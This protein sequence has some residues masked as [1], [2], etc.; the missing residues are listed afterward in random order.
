MPTA[1][2]PKVLAWATSILHEL[3]GCNAEFRPGQYEA[4]ESAC[5]R[6]RTL[7]VQRT[8]WGK[9]LVYFI[10]TKMLRERG[11]GTTIVVSP[12]I[13]LMDNQLAAART[14][15]LA[16]EV[17]NSTVEKEDRF[18]IFDDLQSSATGI[19][20]TTPETLLTD[21][22]QHVLGH[23]RCGLFVIDEAHCIS[24][25]GHDFRLEYTRLRQVIAHLDDT[26][27]L[28]T[29]ATATDAVVDDICR[30][31]GG[32]VFVSRG[33][34]VRDSLAIQVVQAPSTRDKYAWLATNLPLIEGSGIVYCTTTHDCDQL[35]RF[36]RSEGIESVAYHSQRDASE[37]A[38]TL[39]LFNANRIK[40]LV[41]TSALGMGYDKDDIAFVVHFQLPSGIVAYYQQ[42]GRAGRAL[43]HAYAILLAG[44]KT[45][46]KIQ[47]HFIESAFPTE[48]ETQQI[49]HLIATEP[50]GIRF[51]DLIAAANIRQARVTKALEFLQNDGF[52]ERAAGRYVLTDK[53]FAY[54]RAHYEEITRRR[55]AELD[56]M[57]EL[58]R[59]ADCLSRQVVAALGDTLA[60][61]CGRCANCRGTNVFPMQAPSEDA[62]RR[63]SEFCDRD[64][65]SIRPKK[66]WPSRDLAANASDRSTVMSHVNEEGLSLAHLGR[67]PVGE[68]IEAALASDA[69]LPQE[70]LE[71]SAKLL[72][73]E[74]AHFHVQAI[75]CIPHDGPS[76]S[77]EL[78][79]R[80]S[81]LLGIPCVDALQRHAAQRQSE[82]L[83]RYYKCQNAQMALSVRQGVALPSAV[84]LVDDVVDSAWTLTV[85]G[86]RLAS[87]RPG[88]VVFPFALADASYS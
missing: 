14:L 65:L 21:D 29:T 58:T 33:P 60:P 31:L 3:Y 68:T 48:S 57:I 75:V 23:T 59:S 27:L 78:A 87:A 7:V 84:L 30:Q 69:P 49:V 39:E 64:R 8:G 62:L 52:V 50:T 11:H 16:C 13:S 22:V 20:F 72:A 88:I 38:H 10:A 55:F 70:L 66:R 26:R 1:R 61:V 36:L 54:D 47:R 83:N 46:L 32:D 15:G 85:A 63:A 9:S 53:P 56:E 37:R 12:L 77:S 82:Q 76:H 79:E 44:D 41:A 28:A 51:Y 19:L 40:A 45:D 18:R 74:V 4:I 6:K 71:R 2:Y 34:L 67:G 5:T 80:L 86:A 42:I 25:W 35:A 17:L 81:Y 24:D 73:P 43:Q